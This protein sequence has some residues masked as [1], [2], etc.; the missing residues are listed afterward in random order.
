LKILIG[1]PLVFAI[2]SHI[3]H[4]YERLSLRALG[5]FVIHVGDR[6]YGNP[7]ADATMLACSYDE[8]ARRIAMRGEH[9]VPF[10]TETNAGTIAHAFRSAMYAEKPDASYFELPCA[11]FADM[12]Q[13]KK[14]VWAPDGDEAFDDG[15]YVLQFD[16]GNSVRLVAFKSGRSMLYDP[17]TLRDVSLAADEFYGTL[18]NWI[19]AFNSIWASMPKVPQADSLR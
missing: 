6:S 13:S 1:N 5:S 9:N 10:A 11:E 3:A 16:T 7:A 15:S 2:E 4:A 18:Q 12:I 19:D 8:V 17:A 14:I